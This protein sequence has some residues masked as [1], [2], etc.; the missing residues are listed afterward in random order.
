[1]HRLTIRPHHSGIPYARDTN[2]SRDHFYVKEYLIMTMKI[3]RHSLLVAAASAGLLL[4]S[5]PLANA[6]AAP[7][8]PPA[9]VSGGQT[10]SLTGI[11]SGAAAGA[12][13][14]LGLPTE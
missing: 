6:A 12:T 14:V 8:S 1:V 3:V 4:A 5:Q 2:I 13:P 11:G 10:A 7:I 9:P